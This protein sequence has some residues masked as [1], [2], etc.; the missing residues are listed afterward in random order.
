MD[1]CAARAH[2]VDHDKRHGVY[3]FLQNAVMIQHGEKRGDEQDRRQGS[4]GEDKRRILV[5]AG[6]IA[7][8]ELCASI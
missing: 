2:E 7:E 6:E 1:I 3:D 4:E 8:N 5:G